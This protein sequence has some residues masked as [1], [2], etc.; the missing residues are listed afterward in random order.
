MA[1]SNFIKKLYMVGAIFGGKAKKIAGIND[2]SN[3]LSSTEVI[4]DSATKTITFTNETTLPSWLTVGKFFRT[5]DGVAKTTP[6]STDINYVANVILTPNPL[7]NDGVLFQVLSVSG[8]IITV[9]DTGDGATPVDRDT[10]GLPTIVTLEGRIAIVVND[11]NICRINGAGSSVYNMENQTPTAVVGDGSGIAAAFADHFHAALGSSSSLYLGWYVD[12]AA[13]I[14]AHPAG[15][16]GNYANVGS[17]DTMWIWDSDTN[18]WVDSGVA[19]ST[20]RTTVSIPNVAGDYGHTFVPSI[21]HD[22]ILES[23]LIQNTSAVAFDIYVGTAGGTNDI[24]TTFTI[25]A[26]DY[27]LVNT[28]TYNTGDWTQI[29]FTAEA[30]NPWGGTCN[31]EVIFKRIR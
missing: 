7:T 11:A 19:P 27:L 26:S 1:I 24:A 30:Y 29:F 2:S 31:I 25:P 12:D 21:S 18:A 10:T 8:N 3:D 23:I 5:Y 6:S 17:T 4:W 14:A 9:D 28:D 20:E 15:I 22:F 13:L 16:D